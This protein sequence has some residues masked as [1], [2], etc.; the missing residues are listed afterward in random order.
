M[1]TAAV[2]RSTHAIALL[3]MGRT[4]QARA[5]AAAPVSHEALE[6]VQTAQSL[7]R[8]VDLVTGVQSNLAETLMLDVL[9]Q[10]VSALSRHDRWAASARAALRDDLQEAQAALTA[11]ALNAAPEAEEPQRVLEAW[12][13]SVGG[14]QAV[15]ETLAAVTE[16][17]PELA[18]LS[19]RVRAVRSLLS[20][21][22]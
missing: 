20:S 12:R 2:S 11:Q 9:L 1:N 5:V 3:A 15:K 6:I 18:R 8:N 14:T 17:E 19:V 13:E 4:E 22:K 10:K 21:P 7:G 16:L